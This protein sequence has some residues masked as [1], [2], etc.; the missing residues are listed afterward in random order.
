MHTY[1]NLV[2]VISYILYT[3]IPLI[4]AYFGLN[5]LRTSYQ[6]ININIE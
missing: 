4:Y 6:Y 2:I 1:T 3:K 5:Y